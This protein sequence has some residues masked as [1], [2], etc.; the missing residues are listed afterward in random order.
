MWC[1][2]ENSVA[3]THTNFFYREFSKFPS[4]FQTQA[5]GSFSHYFV[6][7]IGRK[8]FSHFLSFSLSCSVN[9][10][11]CWHSQRSILHSSWSLTRKSPSGRGLAIVETKLLLFL[12]TDPSTYDENHCYKMSRCTDLLKYEICSS[13]SFNFIKHFT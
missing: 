3:V 1:P 2:N 6:I 13:L 11:H 5:R 8:Y 12:Y 4:F 10:L 9:L 7:Y